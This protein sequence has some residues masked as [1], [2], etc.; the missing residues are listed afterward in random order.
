MNKLIV[1][2]L[3][4]NISFS[5]VN[6]RQGFELVRKLSQFN[7]APVDSITETNSNTGSNYDECLDDVNKVNHLLIKIVKLALDKKYAM[8]PIDAELLII[9]AQK[10]FQCFTK[11]M[12]GSSLNIDPQCAIDHL[13][14]AG[15]LLNEVLKDIAEFKWSKIQ[16]DWNSMIAILQDI[17][18]C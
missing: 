4:I 10:T 7:R 8:I 17:Q 18:N 12:I 15:N 16:N 11:K 1:F 14:K 5:F 13:Q 6:I 9:E 3:A 2:V